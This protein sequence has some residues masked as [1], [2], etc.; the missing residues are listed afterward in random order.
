MRP[1][2]DDTSDAGSDSSFEQ[3]F[4]LR[5]SPAPSSRRSSTSAGSAAGSEAS[6]EWL[7]EGMSASSIEAY[8]GNPGVGKP[9]LDNRLVMEWTRQAMA[10]IESRLHVTPVTN[11]LDS[12]MFSPDSPPLW[13]LPGTSFPCHSSMRQMGLR[14]FDAT[15]VVST[16]RFPYRKSASK[17]ARHKK[18]F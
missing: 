9:S 7:S 16:T 14:Y 18:K 15:I 8:I 6:S 13:D 1:S 5:L 12:F 17:L 10:W 4:P 3:V 11:G 2:W